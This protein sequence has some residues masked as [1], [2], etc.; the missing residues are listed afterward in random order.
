MHEFTL[1]LTAL[2]YLSAGECQHKVMLCGIWL[3]W[4]RCGSTLVMQCC[5]EVRSL[6]QEA[7]FEITFLYKFVLCLFLIAVV[8][9]GKRYRK[10]V[11]KK[12]MGGGLL[13]RVAVTF[14]S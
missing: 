6:F 9:E 5:I 10:D 2:V 13:R 11:Y 12:P 4:S 1:A 7:A 8:L 14:Y 3:S